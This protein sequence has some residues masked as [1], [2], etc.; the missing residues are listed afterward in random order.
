[1]PSKK[2][3]RKRK[4][5]QR[6]RH[7]GIMRQDGRYV[8]RA[9]GLCPRTGK[10]VERERRLEK[11]GSLN[12]ARR[13]Q[14]RLRE[15][16]EQGPVLPNQRVTVG[17]YARSWIEHLT[18]TKRVRADT[19]LRGRVDALDMHILPFLGDLYIDMLTIKDIKEWQVQM[20]GRTK[21]DGSQYEPVTINNW[22]RTRHTMLKEAVRDLWRPCLSWHLCLS[23]RPRRSRR[24]AAG[25]CSASPG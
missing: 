15:E 13:E 23:W 22:W 17:D 7:R 5:G 2:K 14:Q 10:E 6:T 8:V 21:K 1:M 20:V 3:K 16:I 9:R 4:R 11:G 19:T 18:A 12:D 25:S 24:A